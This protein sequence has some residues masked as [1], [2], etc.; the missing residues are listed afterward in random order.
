MLLAGVHTEIGEKGINL[1][2]GQRARL[3]LARALYSDSD[4]FLLDDPLSAVDSTVGRRLYNSILELCRVR[5]KTVVLATHQFHYLADCD[6]IL[7][8]DG[9][10][11][12][13]A[14][15]T[16]ANLTSGSYSHL[17]YLAGYATSR[18]EGEGAGSAA[19]SAAPSGAGGRV[20]AASSAKVPVAVAV[21]VAAED[22]DSTAFSDE[23]RAR[24]DGVLITQEERSQ[25]E[26]LSSPHTPHDVY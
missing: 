11:R 24:Y 5:G 17:E 6:S 20:R 15:D 12:V 18:A 4:I 13:Q 9:C 8:L 19:P 3:S 21:A 25:E 22:L 1:S 26:V 7:L 23:Q 2:G 16:F 10:G 14:Q